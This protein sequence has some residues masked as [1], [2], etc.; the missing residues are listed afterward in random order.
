MANNYQPN[1]VGG[2][3]GLINSGYTS[4]IPA[5]GSADANLLLQQINYAQQCSVYIGS[6]T[7]TTNG[8]DT[9]N[10]AQKYLLNLVS[11]TLMTAAAAQNYFAGVTPSYWQTSVIDYK[12]ALAAIQAATF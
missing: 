5:A 9:T 7:H 12:A 4:L 2:F 1:T 3:G 6:I 11:T 10:Q 8:Q